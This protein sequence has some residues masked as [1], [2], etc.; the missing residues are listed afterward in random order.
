MRLSHSHQALVADLTAMERLARRRDA[1][2]LFG[3][4]AA[5]LLGP[6]AAM[7]ATCAPT[8]RE[9]MGPFPGNGRN[10]APGPTN[11]VLTAQGAIRSDI[12]ASFIGSE[13]RAPGVPIRLSVTL[14]GGRAC[15][16]L[17]GRA[18][19]LWQNDAAGLYSLYTVPQESYLRGV[20]ATDDNGVA[21]FT[22]IVPGCYGGRSPHM[23]FEVYASLEAAARGERALLSSQFLIPDNVCN[24]VYA[25]RATYAQ[26]MENLRNHPIERDFI[27]RDNSAADL[28]AMTLDATGAAPRGY[29]ARVTVAL[30]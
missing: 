11:N 6:G 2:G 14:V 17:A 18:I 30:A 16:A 28:A 24:A 27:F 19:Y 3:G 10:R 1:L 8:P 22:S 25:D 5:L 9:T 4:A 12:R 13:R 20:Q 21:R 29:D 7:A 15:S 23:H 26:S